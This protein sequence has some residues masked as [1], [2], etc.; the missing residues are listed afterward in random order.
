MRNHTPYLHKS[1]WSRD[2]RDSNLK[3]MSPN[4]IFSYYN[5]VLHPI[6]KRL[7]QMTDASIVFSPRPVGI[8]FRRDEA[9]LA[10]G[11]STR[12]FVGPSISPSK[13][14]L[15]GLPG[16]THS[17]C[18]AL[19]FCHEAILQE[20]LYKRSVDK[21]TFLEL[22]SHLYKRAVSVGRSIGPKVTLLSA[23]SDACTEWKNKALFKRVRRSLDM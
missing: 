13:L 1:H 12:P 19:F 3:P 2:S 23:E 7:F 21:S 8:F 22:S 5:L 11:V 18:T 16:A 10:E 20:P 4:V 9:T 14:S 17:V 6:F 15:F